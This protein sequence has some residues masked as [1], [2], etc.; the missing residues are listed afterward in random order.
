MS[1]VHI[2]ALE[3]FCSPIMIPTAFEKEKHNKN[4]DNKTR[5]I[6]QLFIG[7]MPMSR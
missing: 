5:L 4:N 2:H 7:T 1:S 6:P 3:P